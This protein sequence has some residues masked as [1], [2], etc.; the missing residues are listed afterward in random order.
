MLFLLSFPHNDR[1]THCKYAYFFKKIKLFLHFFLKK[2][3]CV[4]INGWRCV[5][6]NILGFWGEEIRVRR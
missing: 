3:F 2:Y 6:I 4:L 5:S 1:F